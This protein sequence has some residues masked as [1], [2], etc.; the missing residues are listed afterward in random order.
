MEFLIGKR[1]KKA[2]RTMVK[3][4]SRS[5]RFDIANGHAL[6]FFFWLATRQFFVLFVNIMEIDNKSSQTTSFTFNLIIMQILHPHGCFGF[7]VAGNNMETHMHNMLMRSKSIYRVSNSFSG[8]G[9]TAT[10]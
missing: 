3:Y 9:L 10:C 1:S 5:S 7:P 4:S 8:Y 2:T 6:I